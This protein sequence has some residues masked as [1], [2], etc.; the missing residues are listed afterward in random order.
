MDPS[1]RLG[2]PKVSDK[3]SRFKDRKFVEAGYSISDTNC[4][5]DFKF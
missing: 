3:N 1:N 5:S 4:F 2:E